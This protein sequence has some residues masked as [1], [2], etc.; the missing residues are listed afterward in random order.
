[1]KIKICGLK[2]PENIQSIA[3]LNPDWMGFIFYKKSKRFVDMNLIKNKFDGIGKSIGKVA[4]F[5]NDHT[6]EIYSKIDSFGFD[7]VQLHGKESPDA[8]ADLQSKGYRVI[9]AFNIKPDFDFHLTKEYE[10]L[11]DF[12]LFDTATPLH[13]GSGNQFN[14]DILRNYRGET[15]FLLSGGIKIQDAVRIKNLQHPLLKGVDVNSG[16]ETEP[17]L[18]DVGL[19]EKFIKEMNA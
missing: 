10:N 2:N 6:E 19:L 12:F 11:C 8:A 1:M 5:V 13:G 14:W 3:R 4:V 9:K 16:F 17:G 15:P 7:Y 18:K